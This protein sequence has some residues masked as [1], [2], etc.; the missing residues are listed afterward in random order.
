MLCLGV[1]VVPFE[2]A[3]HR[4]E[5]LFQTIRFGQEK[6][7]QDRVLNL[8]NKL[9]RSRLLQLEHRSGKRFPVIRLGVE[10]DDI[11]YVLAK[12]EE[13]EHLFS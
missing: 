2:R 10:A 7:S 13:Y 11:K 5:T 3:W 6:P 12:K 1:E 4:F 8:L 9:G